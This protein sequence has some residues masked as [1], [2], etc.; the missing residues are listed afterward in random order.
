MGLIWDTYQLAGCGSGRQHLDGSRRYFCVVE[1]S[2]DKGLAG[3][4]QALKHEQWCVEDGEVRR[5]RKNVSK[6]QRSETELAAVEVAR[7]GH[8][9][10]SLSKPM[11][12]DVI[13]DSSLGIATW[14]LAC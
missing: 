8:R 5:K 6:S 13:G 14:G 12:R 1:W 4:R 7:A 3:P 9:L 2:S 10:W 11:W